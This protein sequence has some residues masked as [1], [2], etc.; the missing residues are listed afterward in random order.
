MYRYLYRKWHN[1]FNSMH[2]NLKNIVIWI[3]IVPFTFLTYTVLY[4]YLR[5]NS[6]YAKKNIFSII[7]LTKY[8]KYV[9]HLCATCIADVSRPFLAFSQPKAMFMYVWQRLNWINGLGRGDSHHSV[10]EDWG[11]FFLIFIHIKINIE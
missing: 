6:T 8:T 10:K 7:Q 4:I 9:R 3:R 5:L 11:K 2:Y 1:T